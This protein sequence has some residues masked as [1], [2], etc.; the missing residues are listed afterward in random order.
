MFNVQLDYL[1][2]E[3]VE[4]LVSGERP[5]K[6]LYALCTTSFFLH[7]GSFGPSSAFSGS[8]HTSFLHFLLVSFREKGV[9]FTPAARTE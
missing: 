6:Y 4:H 7:R 1:I 3:Y 5:R 9:A 2:C 8:V